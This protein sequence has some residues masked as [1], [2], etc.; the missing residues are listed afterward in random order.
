MPSSAAQ[1]VDGVYLVAADKDSDEQ[2]RADREASERRQPA[3][4]RKQPHD[5]GTNL[6]R[7]QRHRRKRHA[8]PA[9]RQPHYGILNR[10]HH[11]DLS[12]KHIHINLRGKRAAIKYTP[13]FSPRHIA[14][15]TRGCIHMPPTYS[16]A[17]TVRPIYRHSPLLSY[18]A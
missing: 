3:P 14:R 11:V 17:Y 1:I 6:P 13:Q 10:L 12:S 4:D 15:A 9:H 7:A 8:K 2:E 5:G 18:V 16:H